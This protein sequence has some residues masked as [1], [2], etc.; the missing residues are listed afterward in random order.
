MQEF[1]SK[2]LD[3]EVKK[4]V[5]DAVASANKP[6]DFK[7]EPFKMEPV[8]VDSFNMEPIKLDSFKFD[9]SSLSQ[10]QKQVDDSVSQ[11]QKQVD[12]SVSQMQKQIDSSLKSM[13]TLN[14]TSFSLE[15]STKALENVE[16]AFGNVVDRFV[17][18][19]TKINGTSLGF[20]MFDSSK[21][22]A[23]PRL[24]SFAETVK[25]SISTI[26]E[27]ISGLKLKSD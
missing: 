12:D 26:K 9:F 3:A 18:L 16:K 25:I 15:D 2:K 6:I 11:M 4:T 24:E 13:P 27:L 20:P 10:M 1:D 21:V 8:K 7:F 19:V 5:D 17:G 23:L 22:D 14:L